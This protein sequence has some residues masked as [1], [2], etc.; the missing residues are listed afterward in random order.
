MIKDSFDTTRLKVGGIQAPTEIVIGVSYVLSFS[1]N[2][3][4]EVMADITI[5]TTYCAGTSIR[6]AVEWATPDNTFGD[7][8][9]GI[10]YHIIRPDNDEI[11]T[12]TTATVIVIDSAQG[13]QDEL[14]ETD[15]IIIPADGIM[16]GDSL[17][18]RLFRDADA[19]ESG[20]S[21]DYNNDA[22][23]SKLS[24]DIMVDSFGMDMQW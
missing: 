1:K 8:T 13:T 12:E 6:I 11:L 14:I 17:R 2:V 24:Y 5:P 9:W 22:Y 18:I 15:N 23:L 20:A 10:Q 7:V 3:D 4:K 21:D 19:S 16:G